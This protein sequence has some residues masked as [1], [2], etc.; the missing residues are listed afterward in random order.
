MGK[1]ALRTEDVATASFCEKETQAH[2]NDIIY[3]FED[4]LMD[5]ASL[6]TEAVVTYCELVRKGDLGAKYTKKSPSR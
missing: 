6:R 3:L 1:A 4:I 5:K 2:F